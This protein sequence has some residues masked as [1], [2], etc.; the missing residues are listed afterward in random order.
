MEYSGIGIDSKHID[1][2]FNR[3]YRADAGQT[4]DIEGSGIGLSIVKQI[5]ERAEGNIAVQSTLGVGTTFTVDLPLCAE[6]LFSEQSQKPIIE[7]SGR[8][9]RTNENANKPQLL[10]IDDN[11]DILAY[12]SK[13]PPAKPGALVL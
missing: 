6:A 10:L 13:Y 12:V 9:S 4:T 5:V 11:K 1:K 2:I 7:P 8:D 3:F